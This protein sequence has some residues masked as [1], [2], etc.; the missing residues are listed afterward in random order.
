ML[1]YGGDVGTVTI[2][3]ESETGLKGAEY[4]ALGSVLPFP[5]EEVVVLE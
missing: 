4:E 5:I 1:G 3:V 2:M